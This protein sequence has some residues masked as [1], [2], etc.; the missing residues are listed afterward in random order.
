[1]PLIDSGARKS[2][3]KMADIATCKFGIDLQFSLQLCHQCEI[4]NA[5][6]SMT[7]RRTLLLQYKL[8]MTSVCPLDLRYHGHT[9]TRHGQLA[10]STLLRNASVVAF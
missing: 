2:I 7:V 3:V 5:D 9:A 8:H 10:V 1:M 6:V 4:C